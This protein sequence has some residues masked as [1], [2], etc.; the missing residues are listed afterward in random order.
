MT[1]NSDLFIIRI[2]FFNLDSLEIVTNYKS[3]MF[4]ID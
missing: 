3:L 4:D 1:D 2:P